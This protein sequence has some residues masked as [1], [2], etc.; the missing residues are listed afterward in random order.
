MRRVVLWLIPV[1][2]G[3]LAAY[4]VWPVYTALKIR[5]AMIARDA[6]SLVARIVRLSHASGRVGRV[7]VHGVTN[8]QI[9]PASVMVTV[10]PASLGAV[11]PPN[12]RTLMDP[13]SPQVVLAANCQKCMPSR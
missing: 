5:D 10:S 7:D 3:L 12:P 1:V 8:P 13:L 2:I 4:V 6:A 9:S 11:E